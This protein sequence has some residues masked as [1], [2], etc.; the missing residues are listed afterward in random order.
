MPKLKSHKGLL[1]RVKVTA[2]GKVKFSKA[3][4]GH[5]LS[6]KSGDKRRKLRQK[7][8]AK[9]GDIPRL[10]KMLHRPLTPGS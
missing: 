8:V 2:R 1:K 9:R 7:A 10:E 5:L 4:A 3:G 6:H